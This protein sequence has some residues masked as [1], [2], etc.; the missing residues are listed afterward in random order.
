MPKRY[1]VIG[2]QPVWGNHQPGES[3]EADIP[4]AEEAF[5]KDI[6]AILVVSN[7]PATD[8][9][10]NPDAEVQDPSDNG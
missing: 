2:G 8:Q 9:R 10:L 7:D 1:K 6:G 3:F 5:L 4:E